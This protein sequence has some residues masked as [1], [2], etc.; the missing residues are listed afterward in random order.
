MTN[1]H[2][3]K[4]G[5]SMG[6]PVCPL[7]L[8]KQGVFVLGQVTGISFGFTNI[9]AI[10]YSVSWCS[11]PH[12]NSFFEQGSREYPL[13]D[14][15]SWEE[16]FRIASPIAMKSMNARL[17]KNHNHKQLEYFRACGIQRAQNIISLRS[18]RTNVH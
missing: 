6:D 9:P 17:S 5:L 18:N 15:L 11:N 12:S 4:Q 1:V 13:G 2:A 16:A 14:I 10:L 3:E 8:A 7:E